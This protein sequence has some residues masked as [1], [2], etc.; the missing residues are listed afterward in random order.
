[1][2][3]DQGSIIFGYDIESASEAT[4]GFLQGA[5][6]LH[7]KHNVPWTIYLTGQTLSACVEDVRSVRDEPLLSIGQHTFNHVLLKSIYMRPNDGKPIHGHS[8]NFF[9]QGGTLEQ[10]QEEIYSMQTLI[11][12]LLE[13]KCQGLTGPWGYYRGL[14]DRPDILQILSENGIQWIRTNARDYRDCQPT[15]FSEQPFFYI[16]QGFPDILELGVQGYQDD[17]YWDRFD[18]R[19]FGDSYQD[20]LLAM[21]KKVS[22]ENLV[23]NVCSHDHGTVNVETFFQTK[24]VWIEELIIRAKDLGIRFTSPPTLYTE[25]ASA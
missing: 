4:G 2:Q 20:Y 7:Q 22:D 10:I 1:M 21:L 25:M 19:Q 24:G 13:I 15:P 23:W 16:D 14:V 8:P 11:A 5:Q 18:D 3:T 9:C 6:Q 12:D 17:F